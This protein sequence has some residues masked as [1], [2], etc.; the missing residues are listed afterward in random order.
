MVDDDTETRG[1]ADAG[2]D[3]EAASESSFWT[4]LAK[5]RAS[6]NRVGPG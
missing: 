5:G 2:A 1:T 3:R 4:N 6:N